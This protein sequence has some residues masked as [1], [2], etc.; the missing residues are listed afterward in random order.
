M[1]S[2]GNETKSSPS[3]INYEQQQYPAVPLT[4]D[5][6]NLPP[7]VNSHQPTSSNNQAQTPYSWNEYISQDQR[8]YYY[9]HITG[10]TTW[11]K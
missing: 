11:E 1:S 5:I 10:E 4:K 8:L 7:G 6:N 3:Q 2:L 9:N